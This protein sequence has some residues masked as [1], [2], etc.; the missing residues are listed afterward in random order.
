MPSFSNITL[1]SCSAR[2]RKEFAFNALNQSSPS[3][4]KESPF[5][6]SGQSS[7]SIVKRGRQTSIVA[8]I[9]QFSGVVS[10]LTDVICLYQPPTSA[11]IVLAHSAIPDYVPSAH[12]LALAAYMPTAYMSAPMPVVVL[13]PVFT[14]ADAI[15]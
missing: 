14:A 10:N 6:I 13:A 5:D 9:T 1:S 4:C 2:K 12:A 3:K 11:P 15:R 7:S 8:A